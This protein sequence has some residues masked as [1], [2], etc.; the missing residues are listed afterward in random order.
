MTWN[1]FIDDE[2]NVE[3]VTWAPSCMQEKYRNEDWKIAR[4]HY[5]VC[6]LLWEH[7]MPNFVSFDHDLGDNQKTGFDI[8]KYIVEL[9]MDSAEPDKFGKTYEFATTFDFYVHSKN[10]IGKANIEGLLYG[11]LRA[12]ARAI[13]VP[14]D[15]VRFDELYDAAMEDDGTGDITVGNLK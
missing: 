6:N 13:E 10:P 11:Y 4:S 1:L 12:K 15:Q 7:G 8:T 2:R 9:D 14:F 5:D 3:D